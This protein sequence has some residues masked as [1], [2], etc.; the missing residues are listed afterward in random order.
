MA[1]VLIL[2]DNQH[3]RTFINRLLVGINGVTQAFEASTGQE[4]VALFKSHDPQIV[5]LDI[6]LCDEQYTGLDVARDIRRYS[7]DAYIIFVTSYAEYALD[8]IA[9]HPFDYILKPINKD[10][11]EMLIMDIIERL[12]RVRE[13]SG[14]VM[15]IRTSEGLMHINKGDIVFIELQNGKSIFHT[16][17]GTWETRKALRDFENSLG[18]EFMRVHRSFLV[19]LTKIKMIA[20]LEQRSE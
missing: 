5:L 14:S 13:L 12:N 7:K 15:T 4:A 3:I 6:E 2:D 10:R 17:N 11:F 19:N 16:Q 20:Q 9:F 18:E 8:S 1:K